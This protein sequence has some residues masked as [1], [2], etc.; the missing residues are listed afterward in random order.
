MII[1]RTQFAHVARTRIKARTI[2]CIAR[3][4]FISIARTH[5]IC[6]ARNIFICIARNIFISEARTKT[7]YV[8]SWTEELSTFRE[9]LRFTEQFWSGAELMFRKWLTS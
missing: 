5:F 8:D 6:I 7:S 3:N 1:A 4:I 9:G 2:I